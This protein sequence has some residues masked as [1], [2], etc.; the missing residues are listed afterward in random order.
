VSVSLVHRR[1]N[2]A[3]EIAAYARM[4]EEVGLD[5][6]EEELFAL[7]FAK[8]S[9]LLDL[10]CGAGREAFGA[11]RRGHAVVAVDLVH[12]MLANGRGAAERVGLQIEWL[13]AEAGTL[14]FASHS[15]DGAL[16]VCQLLEHFHGRAR[17]LGILREAARVVRPGGRLVLS[18][19]NGLWRPGLRHWLLRYLRRRESGELPKEGRSLARRMVRRQRVLR[20][21]DFADARRLA[22]QRLQFEL[23]SLG[24]RV[25]RGLGLEAAEPGDGWT[26]TVSEAGPSPLGMPFHPYSSGELV[27]DLR[28]AGLRLIAERPFPTLPKSPLGMI[29]ARGAEFWYVAAEVS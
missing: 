19:H 14:P 26:S 6:V 21:A 28:Q 25:A 5:A 13:R 2:S 24:R 3:R 29:A 20:A 23:Q 16:L 8:G 27:H 7:C 12:A 22:A 15:F 11:A 17:R 18:V 4:R 10:G 9:R 1:Y